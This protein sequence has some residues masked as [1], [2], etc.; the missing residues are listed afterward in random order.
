MTGLKYAIFVS[1]TIGS[2]D[3]YEIVS[4][5]VEYICQKY[6]VTENKTRTELYKIYLLSHIIDW[7][8]LI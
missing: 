6:R 3:E 4:G 1:L 5:G 2:V 7:G 8:V